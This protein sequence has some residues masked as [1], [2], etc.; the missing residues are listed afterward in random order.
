MSDKKTIIG[1]KMIQAQLEENSKKLGISID[2]LIDRY[3][4]VGLFTDD[5]YVPPKLTREELLEICKKDVEEDMKK[6]FPPKKHNF[7]TFIGKFNRYED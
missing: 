1:D 3:I 5:Y 6:G 7:E 4:R 2:E